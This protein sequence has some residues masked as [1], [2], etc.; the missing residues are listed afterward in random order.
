MISVTL[1]ARLALLLALLAVPAGAG[2]ASCALAA[3]RPP[4]TPA[5]VQIDD[6]AATDT[7]VPTMPPVLAGPMAT[8]APAPITE[9]RR[10]LPPPQV[11]PPVPP[12]SDDDDDDE[13]DDYGPDD[14]TD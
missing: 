5:V 10:G 6:R 3:E 7:P 14:Y 2:V 8:T 11:V 4:F 13:P 12:V 9:S 1:T